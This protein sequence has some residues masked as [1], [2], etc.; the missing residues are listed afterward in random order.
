MTRQIVLIIE[1][2]LVI[3]D[4][5]DLMVRVVA[6]DNG[7]VG[8]PTIDRRSRVTTDTWRPLSNKLELRVEEL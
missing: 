4:H 6:G 5:Q 8:L 1:G 2:P 3:L 7:E